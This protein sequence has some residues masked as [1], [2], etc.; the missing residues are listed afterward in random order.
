MA[1][2][3]MFP[4]GMTV[5]PGG[6]VPL[7]VFEPRYV[8]LVHD[9]LADDA[10]PM[11]FGVVMIERGHEVGG[12]DV[13]ADIGTMC[14]IADMRVMPGDRYAV[15]IVGTA[16]LRVVGWLPDDPYPM[17]DVDLW[18]DEGETP[19][20]IVERIDELHDRVRRI[21]D[22]VRELG[23]GAP[24]PDAEI[25]DDPAIALYHL[26]S[27]SPLGA[28]D[29]HRVLAAPSLVDRCAVLREALDDAEAVLA[30]RRAGDDPT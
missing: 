30:F 19:L 13:R 16:R 29:R 7:Q 6:V 8:Q 22:V 20:D 23:E 4:L 28:V 15:A 24:P 26:A 12:G 14:R 9:L 21:N 17:A 10:N 3:P 1:V 11:E 25:S 5:L 27:L 2:V 18:P